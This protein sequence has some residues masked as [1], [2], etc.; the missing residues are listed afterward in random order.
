MTNKKPAD[1]HPT[2]DSVCQLNGATRNCSDSLYH[3]PAGGASPLDALLDALADKLAARLQA[4]PQDI[5]TAGD[6]AKR[7]GVSGST[8][9]RKMAAGEFGPLVHLGE[10]LHVATWEGVQ[11]YEAAHTGPI[12][13]LTPPQRQARSRRDNPGPI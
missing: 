2:T 13:R 11:A 5:W 1:A 10:K 8:I 3:A 4:P 6:L 12:M 7:Y 9:R